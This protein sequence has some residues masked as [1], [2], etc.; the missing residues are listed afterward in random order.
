M[1]EQ[2]LT[3]RNLY[4]LLMVGAGAHSGQVPLIRASYWTTQSA[5][6][7]N[8]LAAGLPEEALLPYFAMGKARPRALSN[9]MNR[10]VPHSL[11]LK[12]YHVMEERLTPENLLFMTIWTS[13]ELDEYMNPQTINDI[14]SSFEDRIYQAGGDAEFSCLYDFFCSLRPICEADNQPDGK[15]LV[16]QAAF[17]IAM[18]G[19]HAVYGDLMNV[20]PALQRLR[21]CSFCNPDTLMEAVLAISPRFKKYGFSFKQ[22]ARLR[23][24]D[25]STEPEQ[26]KE[27]AELLSEIQTAA[28]R[29]LPSR[30]IRAAQAGVNAGWYVVS[31][32]MDFEVS[33]NDVPKPTYHGAKQLG[34]IPNGTILYVLEA[35][36][37]QGLH[38]SAGVWGKI[39]WEDAVAWVPM[40][41]L[42]KLRGANPS[43]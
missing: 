21:T 6:W 12:L 36:G 31:D 25:E 34:T 27:D 37:Y 41:L 24:S 28:E 15:K 11:P 19:I 38:I 30:E 5:F 17:R 7:C 42:V 29:A 9:L 35:P 13:A 39:V 8:F 22:A 4:R 43:A 40:N 16:T 3:A 20:S 2:L 1:K 18:L 10:T 33:V 32:W 14:L 26:F 23:Q